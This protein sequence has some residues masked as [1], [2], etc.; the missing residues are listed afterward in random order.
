MHDERGTHT[1]NRGSGRLF[2]HYGADRGAPVDSVMNEAVAE[3]VGAV[4]CALHSAGIV[5][6]DP[7]TRNMILAAGGYT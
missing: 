5:H 1:H 7:T 2:H 6:G 3:D 4:L